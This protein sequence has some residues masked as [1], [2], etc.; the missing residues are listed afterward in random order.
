MDGHLKVVLKRFSSVVGGEV[1]MCVARTEKA[2]FVEY[3]GQSTR[4]V[5]VYMATNF[6]VHKE[7][8]GTT[9]RNMYILKC[10]DCKRRKR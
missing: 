3:V 1:C 2:R 4:H 9:T 7:R 6:E 5:C 10:R 8:L